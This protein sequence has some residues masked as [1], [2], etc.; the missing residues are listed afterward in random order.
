MTASERLQNGQKT[1]KPV[2]LIETLE[3]I[4]AERDRMEANWTESMRPRM[5]SLAM[6]AYKNFGKMLSDL[7]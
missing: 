5:T 7:D 4:I 6:Q 1:E 3:E 2:Y